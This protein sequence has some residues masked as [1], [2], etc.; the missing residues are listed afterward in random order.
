MDKKNLS[1][2]T[3][4]HIPRL[5]FLNSKSLT[6]LKKQINTEVQMIANDEIETDFRG[7]NS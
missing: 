2:K 3:P 6:N 4:S 5:N 1:Y 7:Y